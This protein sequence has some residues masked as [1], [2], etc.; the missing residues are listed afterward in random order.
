[1]QTRSERRTFI[2]SAIFGEKHVTWA[3]RF[4]RFLSSFPHNLGSH[5]QVIFGFPRCKFREWILSRP[6]SVRH[7][8]STSTF[9]YFSLFEK[10]CSDPFTTQF[11]YSQISRQSI[12]PL[13]ITVTLLSNR[14]EWK[15]WVTLNCSLIVKSSRWCRF[16]GEWFASGRCEA[17]ISWRELIISHKRASTFLKHAPASTKTRQSHPTRGY[18]KVVLTS[19]AMECA[20]GE[21]IVGL[22]CRLALSLSLCPIKSVETI[23]NC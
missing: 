2:S 3:T 13:R 19:S 6:F 11:N 22:F 18:F 10:I 4:I 23:I 9:F 1:M 14:F 7:F 8:R 16:R 12:F 20:E 21:N 15:N 17:N 5:K